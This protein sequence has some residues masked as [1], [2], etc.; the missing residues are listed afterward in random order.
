MFL[1]IMKVLC[2]P[3]PILRTDLSHKGRGELSSL[4]H[5]LFI[6]TIFLI[7]LLLT[8]SAFAVQQLKD[9][10]PVPAF[11]FISHFI[12]YPHLVGLILLA[13]WPFFKWIT[14]F[15]WIRTLFPLLVTTF[16][17]SVI[18]AVLIPFVAETFYLIQSSMYHRVSWTV[19][20][21]N[22]LGWF[23]SFLFFTTF[24]SFIELTVLY[25]CFR[26]RVRWSI[27][28]FW[29]MYA[30]ISTAVGLVLVHMVFV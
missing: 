30:A 7:P 16:I 3:H 9:T 23:L 25:L 21:F 5:L 4:P 20:T 14:G 8:E 10:A 26:S 22:P 6:C 29:L 24:V 2:P 18:C 1:M 28:N 17:T 12:K 11:V 13:E 19:N 15:S 27:R